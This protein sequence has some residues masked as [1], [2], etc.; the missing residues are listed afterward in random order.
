VN[1]TPVRSTSPPDVWT[2][3]PS[4]ELA[5]PVAAALDNPKTG[6]LIFDEELACLH[7]SRHAMPLSGIDWS[8]FVVGQPVI[9][10]LR[11]SGSL[12]DES[13]EA[14]ETLLLSTVQVPEKGDRST[15]LRN[16]DG[17]RT[18]TVEVRRIASQCWMATFE[19]VTSRREADAELANLALRDALTGLANRTQFEHS[20]IAALEEKSAAAI[21]MI[22]LDRF[23]SV[24]DTLG[25]PTGDGLLR[26]VAQRLVSV[27]D[28]YGIAARLGGDEFA[29]LITSA[30]RPAEL[31]GLASR[32][33][34]L[35]RRAFLVNGHGIN[36]GSSIGIAVSPDDGETME[37][38]LKR[39][40]LALY[41]SKASG[42]GKFHFFE[43]AMEERA[44][45]RRTLEL[46][47]R[48]ALPL[49]QIEVYYQPQIDTVTK[50]LRGFEASLRWRHPRLGV[51]E[52]E[53]FCPLAEELGLTVQISEWMLR[54][55]CREA[56]GW[57]KPLS[58]SL[59]TSLSQFENGRLVESVI[60]ALEASSLEGS[61]LEIEVT[62]EVLLQNESVV[63]ATLHNLRALGVQV[64]MDEFGTG[65]ASLCQLANFPFDRV[66]IN[67][68]LFADGAGNAKH[69]AI[70]RGI[71]ALGASLGIST[72]G[73]G[74]GTAD[75]LA[76]I[77]ADGCDS[78][79]GFLPSEGFPEGKLRE[80][81]NLSRI[82]GE[83]H[84][85][86]EQSDL[87]SCLLQPQP[88]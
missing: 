79:Q 54:A 36:V 43:N 67:R 55:A 40:D 48:K 42:G 49:R 78:V 5:P 51:L 25:H 44:Q 27:V 7:A 19:D 18:L 14:L 68:E 75:E 16:R 85:I 69:R 33:I 64:V 57:P 52:P 4:G 37:L 71:A 74:I 21:L 13:L 29:V 72:V 50:T 32:I 28:Q 84:T 2:R 83:G 59:P 8:Q 6:F 46:E 22:D 10:F 73:E 53:Q 34:D 77:H 65:Y 24:N 56:N 80:L 86:H 41:H 70:V 88:D 9:Q 26:L 61:R 15:G 47:L 82:L 60:R 12:P 17:S 38:L 20:V 58:V 23:K 39:A 62:E 3:W 45:E 1:L 35:L 11:V 87:Q 30:M 31:A 76:R 63:F 81:I 66:N